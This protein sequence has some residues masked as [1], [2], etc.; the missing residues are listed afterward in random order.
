MLEVRAG[1][2]GA[3]ELCGYCRDV[4]LPGIGE[5]LEGL[6]WTDGVKGPCLFRLCELERTALH[7]L[8][9]VSG[10]KCVVWT[11]KTFIPE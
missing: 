4:P 9:D 10:C 6:W 7:S 1:G 11:I 8:R 5:A 3:G 2:G